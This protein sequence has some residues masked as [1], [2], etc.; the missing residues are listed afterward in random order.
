MQQARSSEAVDS[1]IYPP[2]SYLRSSCYTAGGRLGAESEV[3]S[4]VSKVIP[5]QVLGTFTPSDS[6]SFGKVL[7]FWNFAVVAH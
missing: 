6:A 2:G 5:G 3:E 7:T 4:A 1:G